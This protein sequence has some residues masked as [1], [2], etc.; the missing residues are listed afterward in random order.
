MIVDFK[1]TPDGGG[2]ISIDDLTDDEKAAF[3]R[4]GIIYVLKK[5]IEEDLFNP[6]NKREENQD[7]DLHRAV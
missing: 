2:I 4:Y 7:E 5:A 6:E 1:D 3:I